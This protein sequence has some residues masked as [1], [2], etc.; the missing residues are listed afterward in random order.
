[1]KILD[2]DPNLPPQ[3]GW[4]HFRLGQL[5]E[6]KQAAERRSA[7]NRDLSL[8]SALAIESGDWEL[9]PGILSAYLYGSDRSA[10]DLGR[11]ARVAQII[12]QGPLVEL[13]N[14]A[15]E[16]APEDPYILVTVYS[17]VIEEGLEV[18]LPESS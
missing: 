7:E 4:A 16:N 5:R 15:V 18:A 10:D 14:R 13:V 12:G 1:S 6:A 3:V 2:T 8:E 9:L 17:V 11:A